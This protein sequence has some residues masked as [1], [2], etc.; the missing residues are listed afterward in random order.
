MHLAVILTAEDRA[1]P[2]VETALFEDQ[3]EVGGVARQDLALIVQRRDPEAVDHILGGAAEFDLGA[4]RDVRRRGMPGVDV[5]DLHAVGV[6]EP[7]APLGG[8]HLDAQPRVRDE[9]VDRRLRSKGHPHQQRRHARQHE[10]VA[11]LQRQRL[12]APARP[13][14]ARARRQ[15]HEQR[16]DDD[17]E[18]GDRDREVDPPDVFVGVLGVRH[19]TARSRVSRSAT[20]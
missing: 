8:D 11:D 6:D 9:P 1:L 15:Q 18:H 14:A 12:R 19:L 2:L 5:G 16:A 10:R 17:R 4:G 3:I 7:P 20:A 13:R